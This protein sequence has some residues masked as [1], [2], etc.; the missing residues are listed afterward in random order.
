MARRRTNVF[1]LSFLDAITCG[2]GA[3]VLFYMVINASV[4]L[5]IGSAVR[6]DN[7][8]RKSTC[9]NSRCSRATR[10]LVELRNS[11]RQ[12]ESRARA[13]RTAPRPVAPPA[14]D[15]SQEIQP[16]A[17]HLRR[18]DPGP[19]AST[20]I[21]LQSRPQVARGRDQAARRFSVPERGDAG[22]QDP[23]LCLATATA[24]T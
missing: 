2:F 20:S 1:S 11:K 15:C 13:S 8:R 23:H 17:R 10:Q 21:K 6:R 7:S 14:R 24:S 22:R 12:L 4:G 19:D 9:S 5:R 3:V 18:F 16:R